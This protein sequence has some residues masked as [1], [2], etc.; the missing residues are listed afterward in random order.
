[1]WTSFLPR[2]TSRGVIPW[3]PDSALVGPV[4]SDK[5]RKPRTGAFQGSS[6][7]G[8]GVAGSGAG[9]AVVASASP[10]AARA[11]GT[12][13]AARRAAA[14]SAR[15]RR[16]RILAARGMLCAAREAGAGGLGQARACGERGAGGG[17]ERGPLA[18]LRC[19]RSRLPALASSS[20]TATDRMRAPGRR[21]KPRARITSKEQREER[22]CE[23]EEPGPS[24]SSSSFKRL[25]V[26]RGLSYACL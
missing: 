10:S 25:C 15:A 2:G 21:G 13:A 24:S 4:A 6:A 14:N 7:A 17:E 26:A 16:P 20:C 9:S 22:W 19:S 23:I 11:A 18:L 5:G 8:T 12:A 3:P 1:V